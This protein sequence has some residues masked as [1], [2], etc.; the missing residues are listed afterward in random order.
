MRLNW[1]SPLPPA[2]T[3]IAHFTVRVLSALRAHAEVTLWTDQAE[4]DS[5]L[6]DYAEV[7]RYRVAQMPWAELNR[8]D[9]NVYNIGNNPNYHGAIWEVSQRQPGVVILHDYCLQELF[10]SLY[11][12]PW[13]DLEAYLTQMEFYYGA[14]GRADGAA[15]YANKMR[16]MADLTERYPLTQLALE[17]ALG[18]LVHTQA[19]Y[20]SLSNAHT[21][22]LAYAPLPFV[23][24]CNERPA[25][26]IA[27]PP[28][29]SAP[30]Y[31]LIVFGYLGR[32]R[33]LAAVLEAL[34]QLPAREQF[35]LHIF[36]QITDE[37]ELRR[38]IRARDLARLVTVHGFVPE[39]GLERALAGAHLALNLRYPTMGEASGSQLRI[40]SHALPSLVTPVGWYAT[41]PPDTV[42]FVRP[43]QEVADLSAHLTAFLADP[44][45]FAVM[46]RKG[47]ARYEQEHT[48]EQYAQALVSLLTEAQVY[49]PRA[50]WQETL[51]RAAAQTAAWLDPTAA[52][53]AQLQ[54][55]ARKNQLLFGRSRVILSPL[56]SRQRALLRRAK[57]FVKRRLLRRLD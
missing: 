14:R 1:F 7:R 20:A 45:H 44:A 35:R 28:R 18:A 11:L 29:P 47:R 55:A 13:Q 53:A 16:T 41:L 51:A 38:A 3:D 15:C 25:D 46:G 43:E 54:L 12:G 23:A 24:Q 57:R 19:A 56:V 50:V 5:T 40:W 42:A 21:M 49:R 34:A 26:T 4:W 10:Y 36:G 52:E 48:P 33:R 39:A 27:L 17:H 32:N 6:A 2:P 22:P 31:R 37:Q 9:M 8:G 30:P